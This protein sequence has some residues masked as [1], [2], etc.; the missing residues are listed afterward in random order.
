MINRWSELRLSS[1]T[2][3]TKQSRSVVKQGHDKKH[4]AAISRS[5][6]RQ[7]LE[8]GKSSAN[9]QPHGFGILE[10]G[11][12]GL[13][14]F[15]Y[16]ITDP[17]HWS[18]IPPNSITWTIQLGTDATSS[19]F[20]PKIRKFSFLI[21]FYFDFLSFL[22]VDPERVPLNYNNPACPDSWH[23]YKAFDGK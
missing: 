5:S 1:A 9:S 15:Q 2:N 19:P 7:K 16:R 21:S 12:V 17:R 14:F 10:L 18:R 11:A 4:D 23:S 22:W 6:T 8:L 3:S 13:H 20:T